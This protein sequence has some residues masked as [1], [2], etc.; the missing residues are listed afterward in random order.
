MVRTMTQIGAS[1]EHLN[2]PL[3]TEIHPVEWHRD[4]LTMTNLVNMRAGWHSGG[5][6]TEHCQSLKHA[7]PRIAPL[8]FVWLD[9]V[10]SGAALATMLRDDRRR[11]A[12]TTPIHPHCP[13]FARKF[14]LSTARDLLRM[15]MSARVIASDA[16]AAVRLYNETAASS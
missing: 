1:H 12:T 9:E 5:A 6:S 10:G 7:P 13:M 2:T 3:L 8:A 14:M 4:E 15:L 11:A 16:A